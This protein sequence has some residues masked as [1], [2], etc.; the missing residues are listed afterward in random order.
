[1]RRC[2][3]LGAVVV[4]GLLTLT[5]P[6]HAQGYRVRLDTWYMNYAYRGYSLDSIQSGDVVVDS[7]T[8]GLFTPDGH[9]VTC[10]AGAA[11]CQ[12][13]P[14]KEEQRGQ[15]LH[16]TLDATLWGLGI[17]GLSFRLK[18][19]LSTDFASERTWPA[20]EP[21]VELFEGFAEY[22]NDWLTAV[23]G[24]FHEVSR[25]GW[26]GMDGAKVGLHLFDRKLELLGFGGWGLVRGAPLPV[27]SEWINPLDQFQPLER[28]YILGGGLGWQ[29]GTFQGRWIY[30]REPDGS[31]Q[32]YL[33]SER[34]ALDAS[35]RPVREIGIHGGAEYNIAVGTWGTADVTVDYSSANRFMRTS[36][37][38]RRYRPYFPLWTIWEAF[39]PVGYDAGWASLTLYPTRGLRLWG[40]G[41]VFGYENTNTVTPNVNV[42][43]GGWRWTIGAG[44]DA[45]RMWRFAGNYYV[46]KSVGASSLGWDLRATFEP[47]R[48]F[49]ATASGGYLNRP[50]EYRYNDAKTWNVGL[51]LDWRP[52]PDIGMMVEGRYYAED[53]DRPDAAAI[54]EWNQFRLNA[55]LTLSF[56]S[57]ADT[58]SLSPA[59][60][61]VPERRSAQ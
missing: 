29:L 57:G 41:E 43:D 28:G 16:S 2:F 47:S 4:G 32:H 36:M 18:A 37:G 14:A 60:L 12:F 55:G 48:K 15:P 17:P 34:T 49:Y 45:I 24:R 10:G 21:S 31:D 13:Y 38:W 27:T 5:S 22:K 23:G 52:M 39:S 26:T 56:G 6:L 33:F 20:T 25:L 58:P 50:L 40:K 51:R 59:I 7:A 61:R 19:R 8:G 30:Q 54:R 53:R 44:Y 42:A 11:Y 46:N 35:W 3:V 1:M 9:V